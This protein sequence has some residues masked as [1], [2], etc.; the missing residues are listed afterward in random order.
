MQITY[1]LIKFFVFPAPKDE[2]KAFLILNNAVDIRNGET[3]G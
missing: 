2:Q 3:T 1:P